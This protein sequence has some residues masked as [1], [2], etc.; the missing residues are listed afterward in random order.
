MEPHSRLPV[1]AEAE[2]VVLLPYGPAGR[3]VVPVALA[4]A[5]VLKRCVS[6]TRSQIQEELCK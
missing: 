2:R 3:V 6:D 5:T 4:E 1:A